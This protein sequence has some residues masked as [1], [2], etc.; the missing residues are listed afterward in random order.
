MAFEW[1]ELALGR[2]LQMAAGAF[3]IYAF[4]LI[5]LCAEAFVLY[6]ACSSCKQESK[7]LITKTSK[8]HSMLYLWDLGE[9]RRIVSRE[10][11][12]RWIQK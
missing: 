11:K 10:Y 6:P 9:T 2:E 7:K 5:L 1:M 3:D 4:M 12:R 8:F